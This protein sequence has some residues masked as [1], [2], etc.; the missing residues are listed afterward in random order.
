MHGAKVKPGS[1]LQNARIIDA[2]PTA[3]YLMGYPVP[4]D[5]D[6]KVLADGITIETLQQQPVDFMEFAFTKNGETMAY[7]DADREEV[8]ARLKSLGYL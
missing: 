8:E 5:M 1:R 7:S 2:A 4:N 6:G 3:L